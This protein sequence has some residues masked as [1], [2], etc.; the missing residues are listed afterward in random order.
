[1]PPYVWILPCILG[2]S[3]VWMPSEY[4]WTLPYVWTPPYLWMPQYVWIPPYVWMPTVHIQHK[5]SMLCQTERV[6]IFPI[7]CDAPYVWMPHMFRCP[8]MLVLCNV[9][10]DD[11]M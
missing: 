8:Y 1:M 11:S 2:H 4:V 3:Y 7:H 6:S 5:K 9:R 10:M